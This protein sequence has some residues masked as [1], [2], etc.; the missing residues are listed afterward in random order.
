MP[1]IDQAA[2]SAITP[3]HT[4]SAPPVGAAPVKR[5][6]R[7]TESRCAVCGSDAG[8]GLPETGDAPCPDCGCLLWQG[9]AQAERLRNRLAE[10]FGVEP[11]AVDSGTEIAEIAD[12]SLATLELV[13]ELD[14]E[15]ELLGIDQRVSNEEA[16]AICT[17]GDALRLIMAR[18]RDSGQEA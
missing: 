15:L 11:E 4:E 2:G 14:E 3:S 16:V 7:V 8:A 1:S 9:L 13:M 6:S 17:I 12:D 18:R 10:A 5:G